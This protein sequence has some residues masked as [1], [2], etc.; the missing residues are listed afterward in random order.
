[1]AKRR[2]LR[3]LSP[4]PMTNLIITDVILRSVSRMTRRATEKQLLKTGYRDEAAEK[5]VKGRSLGRTLVSAALARTA[6][7]SLPGALA[8]GG[9]LL[10]KTII[11]RAMGPKARIKGQ[12]KV[13]ERIRKAED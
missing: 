11:D 7:K 10:A 12:R 6:T 13:R 4:N 9:G 8:V 2:Q 3:G 5:V 1:M